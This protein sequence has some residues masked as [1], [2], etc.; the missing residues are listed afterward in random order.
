FAKMAKCWTE[1]VGEGWKWSVVRRLQGGKTEEA[2]MVSP[3][4][5]RRAA[6]DYNWFGSLRSNQCDG[7]L[8]DNALF[9]TKS[10]L[11]HLAGA[12][13]RYQPRSE[14]RRRDESYVGAGW[15]DSL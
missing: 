4:P 14:T 9:A 15:P 7:R 8:E 11:R 1:S 6:P 3:L 13:G 12:G 2:D 10:Y 5:G